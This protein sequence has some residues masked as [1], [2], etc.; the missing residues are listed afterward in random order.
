L[1][2]DEELFVADVSATHV[3]LLN[4]FNVIDHHLLIVTREFVDQEAWLDEPDFEALWI[5]MD[6]FPALG[7]YN[8]GT[9]AGASQPHKHLQ[10][11]P[12]PLAP[13]GPPV[14]IQPLLDGTPRLPFDHAFSPLDPA[15]LRSPREAA[16]YT[17]DLYRG[18]LHEVRLDATPGPYNLLVTREWM[19]LVPREE[20][21]FDGVSV[22]ALGFAGALLVRDRPQ[23]ERLKEIGPLRVLTHVARRG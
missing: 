7:F 16:A 21:L 8:A 19:L 9:V 1:P 15:R 13:S 10:L 5:C 4:K 17:L 3:G 22:N 18:L 20:E 14:P 11:V 23:L 12:L 6:E 2:Y